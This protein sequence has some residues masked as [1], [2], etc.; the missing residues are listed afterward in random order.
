[1]KNS[2]KKKSDENIFGDLKKMELNELEKFKKEKV[3]SDDELEQATVLYCDK[4]YWCGY[5]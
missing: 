1:M 2:E 3:L 5:C 4:E